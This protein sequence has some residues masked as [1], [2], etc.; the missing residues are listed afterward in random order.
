MKARLFKTEDYG[1]IKEWFEGHGQSA[2]SA[3][4]LPK[5]GVVAEDE[6]GTPM[7]AGWIYQ[8]NSIGVAWL[9]WLVTNPRCKPAAAR[10]ALTCVLEGAEAI[11]R[12]FNYGVLF[13]MT[14]KNGLGRWLEQNGFKSNHHGMTQYF[15]PLA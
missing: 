13:T 6:N 15:K 5:C 7:A 14:H 9:A 12:E 11:C 3:A 8:D 1:T 4:L 10:R 2:V